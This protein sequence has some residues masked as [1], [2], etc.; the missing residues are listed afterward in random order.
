MHNNFSPRVH[1]LMED[2]GFT[3]AAEAYA[4]KPWIFQDKAVLEFQWEQYAKRYW[5]NKN[6]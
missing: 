6:R 2:Y 5:E 3:E 1:Q 4:E